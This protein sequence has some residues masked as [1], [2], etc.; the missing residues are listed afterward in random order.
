MDAG[1]KA[2]RYD[3]VVTMDGDRQNDPADIPLMLEYL[4]ENDL[5]VVSGWRKTE[6]K[7][8]E[9]VCFQRSEFFKRYS[10]KR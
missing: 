9:E 3:Y 5:D 8:Y 7:L 1:I 2:A 4:I 10:C 6:R